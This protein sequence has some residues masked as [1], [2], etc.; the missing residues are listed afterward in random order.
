MKLRYE[1]NEVDLSPWRNDDHRRK[2]SKIGGVRKNAGRCKSIYYVSPIAGEMW[3][4]GTWEHKYAMWL[5]SHNLTW[6]RNTQH[7]PY[8]FEGKVRKYF[9]DFYI[10]DNDTFVEIK[11]YETS[12][13]KAKWSQFPKT[14]QVLKR[15]DLMRDPYNLDLVGKL[16]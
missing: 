12:K 13:D 2:M 4:N 3:L 9:P 1:R 5:D 11:G 8:L 10:K 6:K 7:F 16:K 14:L 15:D